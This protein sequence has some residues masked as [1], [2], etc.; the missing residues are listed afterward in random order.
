MAQPPSLLATKLSLPPLRR[1]AVHR[2]RLVEQ[3][4]AGL[5]GKLTLIVA[6][7]GFG[8]ST[9]VADWH[10]S[11]D[12]RAAPIGWVSLDAADNDP[13]RVWTHLI[14]AADALHPGAGKTALA[15]LSGSQ[16]PLI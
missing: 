14:A 7:A 12:T 3:L 9:L 8:K 1:N 11:S 16:P 5:A 13:A 2:P 15:M 10:A 4:R 6:P